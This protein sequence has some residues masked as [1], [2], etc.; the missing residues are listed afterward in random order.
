MGVKKDG[1]TTEDAVCNDQLQTH[2]TTS[3]TPTKITSLFTS[4]KAHHPH[5]GAQTQE[6]HTSKTTTSAPRPPVTPKTKGQPSYPPNTANQIGKTSS[7]VFFNSTNSDLTE[8]INNLF[9]LF[10]FGYPHFWNC[11]TARAD[12]CDLQAAHYSLHGEKTSSAKYVTE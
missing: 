9:F 2:A 7:A 4:L 6:M 3:P 12:S 10:R 1:T 11:W 5:E 8:V